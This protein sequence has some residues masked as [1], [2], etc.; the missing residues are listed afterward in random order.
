MLPTS[1]VQFLQCAVDFVCVHPPC[2]SYPCLLALM[3]LT[4]LLMLCNTSPPHEHE[5]CSPT[6]LTPSLSLCI[7]YYTV[8]A[9][10][11]LI[12][13]PP[14]PSLCVYPYI[15]LGGVIL[16]K[17]R[18]CS[19]SVC[20][21]DMYLYFWI[22]IVFCVPFKTDMGN[23]CV[24][25]CV[26]ERERWGRMGCGCS[27]TIPRFMLI[28]SSSLSGVVRTEVTATVAHVTFQQH[29]TSHLVLWLLQF[30]NPKAYNTWKAVAS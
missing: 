15:D 4:V 28:H 2:N 9:H 1:V 26:W 25:V 21:F 6:P 7:M 23:P 10:A 24:C 8:R 29:V 11:P 27:T 20:V 5:L 17:W 19:I 14:S 3:D 22:A 16:T 30:V 13:T 18:R 12:H